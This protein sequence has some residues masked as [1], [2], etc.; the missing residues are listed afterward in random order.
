M[1]YKLVIFDF[2]GTL[3]DSFPW[4]LGSFDQVARKFQI[5]PLGTEQIDTLRGYSPRE[6]MARMRIPVW[7]LPLVAQ[8]VRTLMAQSRDEIKLFGGV[9]HVLEGL[10]E[11]R[12]DT[13]LL[14]S[15]SLENVR[16]ILTE[17]NFSR[18]RYGEFGLSPLGKH[19]GFRSL[20]KK[21]GVKPSE[22]LYVGDT[23]TDAEA[24][25]AAGIVFVGVAWGYAT[26][27]ALQP[28]SL[29]VLS[30]GFDELLEL[31]GQ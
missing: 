22:A 28:V 7:K 12:I 6:L 17:P 24:A 19:A 23:L 31:V 14:T 8:H 5:T 30:K 3:A 13:A 11:R 1:K 26:A 20:L 25:R 18:F 21:S 2:D 10:A 9:E 29:R 15:N 4:L 27:A 16:H